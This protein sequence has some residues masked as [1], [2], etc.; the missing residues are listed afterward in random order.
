MSLPK[1]VC[2]SVELSNL[3]DLEIKRLLSLGAIVVSEHE[4]GEFISEVFPVPKPN[5][6]IRLILNLKALNKF[7]TYEHFKMEHLDYVTDLVFKNDV[8]A[9]IDRSDAYF[10]VPIHPSHWRYLKFQW[11]GRLLAYKV[12]VFGLTCS[13]RVFTRIC[14]PILARLRGVHHIRCSM[15]IETILLFFTNPNQ[16]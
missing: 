6:N 14:K 11:R 5:G 3:M 2:C 15:F 13:P 16:D 10:S 4:P 12:L 8:M 1:S 9:S 7:V